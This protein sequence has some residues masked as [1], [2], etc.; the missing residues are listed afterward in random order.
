MQILLKN[1]PPIEVEVVVRTVP[2]QR[3]VVRGL[4]NNQAVYAKKF[5]GSRAQK[6]FS[7]DIAGVRLLANANIATPALLFDG[8]TEA[9]SG[10]VAIYAAIGASQNAEVAYAQLSKNARFSLMQSLVKTVAQHHRADLI[11][12]DLY[13]KNFLVEAASQTIYTLDGDGIRTLNKLFK[14]K[15]KR[16]N[17]AT[18]FSKMDVQ[19]DVWIEDL[20]QHYC[21]ETGLYFSVIDAANVWALT[22]SIRAKVSRGYADKKVFRN[23]TDVKVTQSFSRYVAIAR[24]FLV[25]EGVLSDLDAYLADPAQNIKNGH[26]CTIAK[27][28]IAERD[29]VVKRYNIKGLMHGLSRTLRKSRAAV[30][31][32]NAF[33]LNMANIATPMPLALVEERVGFLRK[34]AYFVSEFVDAPDVAQFFAQTTDTETKQQVALEVTQLFYRL[35]LLKISH[36]DC[37]ASNIKIKDGKPLLLDLDAMQANAWHFEQK[38]VKDLKRFM[39]NWQQDAALTAIFKDAFVHVYDDVDDILGASLLRRAAIA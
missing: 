2:Q 35:Y 16:S 28:N 32:A 31:W 37:K 21:N 19:D 18:L 4:W 8:E 1:A 20:Y 14:A 9:A 29:V 39:R 6:H 13:F 26:T 30:S 36:G 17:L 3:E 7:R 24:D 33:R 23:C 5:T 27:A 34:R 15:Q 25:N 11:Q 22:Q 12:T 38:H 10:F